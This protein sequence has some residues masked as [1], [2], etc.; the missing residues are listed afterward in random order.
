MNVKP[1]FLHC[2]LSLMVFF[3]ACKNHATPYALT[4]TIAIIGDTKILD[5][6]LFKTK[7]ANTP[8]NMIFVKGGVVQVGD[9]KNGFSQEKPSL[10]LQI[11]PFFMD[12]SPVTVAEFSAFVKATNYVTE[13]EKFGDAGFIGASS[14]FKWTLKKGA[15]W[16][17]PQGKDFLQAIDNHPVTQI[18]WNDAKAYAQWAG[19]RLP[20]EWE[21]EHAARNAQNDQTLYAVGNS[22][23]KADGTWLANIWQGTFPTDNKVEDGFAG[24][25]P[26]GY[27]GKTPL[28]LTDMVGNVWQW[29]DNS[30]FEYQ[31]ARLAAEN[32]GVLIADETQKAQKGGSFL[33]E[34]GWCHAYRVS[35]RS[36]ASPETSL[37]HV[38]FRCVKDVE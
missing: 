19:K 8:A 27:F 23:Q 25:S 2:F 5:Q 1:T 20:H 36:F 28:G 31:N 29:C 12:I 32:N 21:W 4:P 24:T 15:N 26:V 11:K 10:W 16:Q 13:A 18:S 30:K 9:E 6:D 17:Y 37:M 22:L 38:G 7:K 33:C 34:R 35:G 3:Y 14:G